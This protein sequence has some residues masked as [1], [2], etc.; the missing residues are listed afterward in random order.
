VGN[1][2]APA[3]LIGIA[4]VFVA[5]AAWLVAPVAGPLELGLTA[6][7]VLSLLLSIAGLAKSSLR[8]RTAV[9]SGLLVLMAGFV[10]AN[11]L[12]AKLFTFDPFP[13]GRYSAFITGLLALTVV[14]LWRRWFLARWSALALASAGVV[15]AGLNLVHWATIRSTHSWLLAIHIAGALVVLASLLGEPMRRRFEEHASEIWTS[16]DPMLRALRWTIITHFVAIPML[17]VYGWMQPIVPATAGWA[18]ALAA[19]LLLSLGLAVGRKVIGALGL[20]LG[21]TGLLVHTAATTHLAFE[22]GERAGS[23]A[24]YYTVFWVPAGL[25]AAIFGVRLALPVLRLLRRS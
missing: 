12:G 6:G 1:H 13:D 22:Q 25:V 11:A 3:L 5:Y 23:I 15:S 20:A 2:R 19:F 14:G 10:V 7:V 16:R 8:V 21:G 4:L 18:V 17:L 9:A 24:L